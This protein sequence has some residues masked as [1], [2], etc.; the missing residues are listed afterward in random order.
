MARSLLSHRSTCGWPREVCE[1]RISPPKGKRYHQWKECFVQSLEERFS[2]D[3][4]LC[5]LLNG[6][7]NP[8]KDSN[9]RNNSLCSILTP[10]ALLVC[11]AIGLV[12]VCASIFLLQ[13]AR[14]RIYF[15]LRILCHFRKFRK[16]LLPRLLEFL[17][18]PIHPPPPLGLIDSFNRF[19]FV[20]QR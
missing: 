14:S 12:V 9:S 20:Y 7:Q 8:L 17:N 2:E 16:F 10:L 1:G 15:E 11:A 5:E 18:Q 19:A 4:A 3:P 13:A 6:Q